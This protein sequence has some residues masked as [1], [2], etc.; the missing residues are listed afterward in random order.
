MADKKYAVVRTD[1]MSGT[2]MYPDLVSIRFEA[3]S[4]PKEVENG[5]IAELKELVEGEGELW[6]AE[7]AKES[8][9]LTDAVLVCS[10]ELFYDERL[11][12]LDQFINEAGVAARGYRLRSGNIFSM[13][14]EGFESSKAPTKGQ[15]VGI[16]ADGKLA[17]DKTG[18][19]KCIA[20]ETQGS[21]TWHVIV[22]GP[23]EAAA[24]E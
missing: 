1:L 6:K 22:V 11:H 8:T 7:A 9:K 18:F 21:Y 3:A 16:G 14:P 13:T 24:G 5:V 4:T 19:G 20:V 23:T 12:N 2:Q 17:N 15:Q 10:P